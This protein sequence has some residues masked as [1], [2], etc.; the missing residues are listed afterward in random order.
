MLTVAA[1]HLMATSEEP[2]I[3]SHILMLHDLLYHPSPRLYTHSFYKAIIFECVFSCA[4]EKE[5]P[6]EA[7]WLLSYVRA[8]MPCL[9]P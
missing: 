3:F 8:Y 5:V 4:H 1:C 2:Q 6:F 9:F 7:S